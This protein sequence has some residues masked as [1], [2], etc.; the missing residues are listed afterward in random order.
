[1]QF[2]KIV[3]DL[4]FSPSTMGQLSIF[5]KKIKNEEIIR[6]IGLV[7]VI[8][9]LMLQLLITLSIFEPINSIDTQ[10]MIN[11]GYGIDN[12]CIENEDIYCTEGLIISESAVNISQGNID[13]S[14]TVAKPGDYINYN[15]EIKNE[16]DT[17]IVTTPKIRLA[18]ILEYSS[19][20]DKNNVSDVTLSTLSW[21]QTTIAPVSTQTRSFTVQL[22]DSVPIT[23]RG[24]FY[25]ES[26]DC[27]MTNY[28]G[29]TLN[30][31]VSCPI[32]KKIESIS[33]GIPPIDNLISI[34]TLVSSFVIISLLYL[35]T[36][37][38]KREI[39]IIR[40]NAIAGVI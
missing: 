23:P 33:L 4:S 6:R 35:R 39:R 28:F 8:L 13:A 11:R 22:M 25:K 27:I 5:A 19:I 31:N 7:F 16:T 14:S 9:T 12:S 17:S 26:H 40:Q 18:D 32:I 30:I 24:A 20:I 34:L 3:S 38:I 21:D 2:K 36:R 10:S 29:N 37:Q 15:I 1:M